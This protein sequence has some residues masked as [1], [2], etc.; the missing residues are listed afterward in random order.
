MPQGMQ[1][2]GQQ[3][4]PAVFKPAAVAIRNKGVCTELWDTTAR[5]IPAEL[6]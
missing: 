5:A 2:A 3:D 4:N 1:T 6:D